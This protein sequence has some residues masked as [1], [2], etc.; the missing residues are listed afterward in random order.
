[1]AS[2][3][4]NFIHF[5]RPSEH[6]TLRRPEGGAGRGGRGARRGLAG[7]RARRH[8]MASAS[9]ALMRRVASARGLRAAAAARQAHRQ[10]EAPRAWAPSA[11]ALVSGGLGFGLGGGVAVALGG[12]GP[13]GA[14]RGGTVACQSTGSGAASAG[15]AR[16]EGLLELPAPVAFSASAGAAGAFGGDLLVVAVWEEAL[17]GAELAA[18]DE[19]YGGVLQAMIAEAEFKAEPGS[20]LTARVAGGG[21]KW[22]SV[23]GM[24]KADA[25]GAAGAGAQHAPPAWDKSAW[26]KLGG[27]V[28]AACK[29]QP[30]ASVGVVA[31]G[32]PALDA[33]AAA[34]A[35]GAL[36]AGVC[37]SAYE[38]T[39]FK[40]KDVKAPQLKEVE[41]LSVFP[42]PAAVAGAVQ[43]AVDLS[44]GALLTRYLVEAPPNVCTP[45]HLADA[46]AAVAADFPETMSLTVLEKEDCE[47]LGMGCYLG[48]AECSDLP[49]KFIH[50][51]YKPPG[52]AKKKVCL[53]GKGL[54][55]DSGGYNIKLAMME[56][57][58]FD[59]GGSGATLGAARAV[60]AIAPPDVECHFI[61]ASCENMIDGKGLR[62][63]DILTAMDGTTVEINNTDA[64]GRLTLCDALLY[65]QDQ[66]V[67]AIVDSATLTGACMVALGT[68]IA[69]MWTPDDGLAASLEA[70]AGAAGEKLWRMP[71]EAGYFEQLKSDCADM[72]NTGTRY[73]GAIT[74]ALFLDKFIDHEKVKW[75]HLDIAG[76]VWD[77]KKGWATGFAAATLAEWVCRQGAE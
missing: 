20:A 25:A 47:K 11:S 59:M 75:A 37:Q 5:L 15:P 35:A 6:T 54:T 22:V 24:G 14:W 23:V 51:V 74:A 19:L 66:G 49:P 55:F 50:L 4:L 16:M 34:R 8:A 67:E 57:M 77:D 52:G 65:A 12:G 32:A 3:I 42:D 2:V 58:K 7:A 30:I 62:P 76:P 26:F 48:V 70:A 68:D 64:E 45:A 63:G 71:L 29:G 61:I 17:E 53:V 38:S 43:R 72:K 44:Q 41:Y 28:R 39:R 69:G 27:A 56:M 1:M 10:A 18:V 73:G 21:T 36:T 9:R 31:A 33:A 13:D 60:G 46:A 40:T